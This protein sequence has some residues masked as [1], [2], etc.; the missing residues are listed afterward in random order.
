MLEQYI[1][2][3]PRAAELPLDRTILDRSVQYMAQ[4]SLGSLD[5]AHLATAAHYEIPVFW[6]CDDHF[7]RVDDVFVEII[8]GET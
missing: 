3:L 2:S 4:Y 7:G 8:R 6:T 1:A 5:A